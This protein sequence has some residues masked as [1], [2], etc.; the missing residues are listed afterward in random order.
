MGNLLFLDSMELTAVSSVPIGFCG[1][2]GAQIAIVNAPIPASIAHFDSVLQME[3][4]D[5]WG[6]YQDI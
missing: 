3:R 4:T 5:K 2:K 1:V 6:T